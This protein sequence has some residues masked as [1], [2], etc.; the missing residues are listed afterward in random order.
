IASQFNDPGMNT[1]YRKVMDVL[2]EKADAD[3]QSNFT[4]TEEMSEKIYVIPP[5]RTRY[6][7][8][9]S[10]NNRNYDKKVNTE[11][12]TAQKLYANYKT[13]EGLGGKVVL[14]KS[15]IDVVVGKEKELVK[16]LLAEFDRIKLDLDPHNWEKITCWEEVFNK[17]KNPVYTFKVRDKEIKIDTH[18]ESLSHL[19]IPK[20]ALPKYKAWGDLLRW[21]LQENIPGEFPYTSGLY[22]FKRTGEDPT[23]MF[24][25]EGDRSE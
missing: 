6:L 18:T 9:I 7:S 11:S 19:Q 24:A 4:I 21:M 13:I 10:E 8:E 14:T 20:V 25:G 2:V 5:D 15:G 23:R 1:L 22:P 12:E 17:Y 3:L 16:L